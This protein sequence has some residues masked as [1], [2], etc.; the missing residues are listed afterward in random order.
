MEDEYNFYW[1]GMLTVKNVQQVADLLFKLLDGKYY[2]FIAANEFFQFRPEVKTRQYL[3][4]HKESISAYC[5]KKNTPPKHAGF[6]V[7]DIS[8]VWGC[9]TNLT[10][11]KKDP[12]FKNPY[13]V[14]EHDRVIITHR[15][16]ARDLLY[17]VIVTEQYLE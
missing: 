12:K 13:I 5:D 9:S 7:D 4:N 15:T 17:W 11:D 1:H 10:E 3:S 14:F 16:P 2:T 8:G 6:N